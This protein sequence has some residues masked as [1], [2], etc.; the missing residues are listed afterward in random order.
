MISR[1]FFIGTLC[2]GK[3]TFVAAE[4]AAMVGGCKGGD[5]YNGATGECN[6]YGTSCTQETCE[7]D[8]GGVWTADCPPCDPDECDPLA[9]TPD[10]PSCTG[11]PE[12][13]DRFGKKMFRRKMIAREKPQDSEEG[14]FCHATFQLCEGESQLTQGI[15]TGFG[16]YYRIAAVEEMYDYTGTE[17]YSYAGMY[18]PTGARSYS[19]VTPLN[20]NYVQLTVKEVQ[21][22]PVAYDC[23]AGKDCLFGMSELICMAPIGTDF[24]LSRD[25]D[26][27]GYES[28]HQVYVPNFSREPGFGPYTINVIGQGVAITELNL[29]AMS[30]LLQPYNKDG[31]FSNIEVVNY[32]WANSYWSNA[33]WVWNPTEST[34]LSRQFM[35]D[36][37]KY[38]IRFNLMHA[39]SRETR[40]EAEYPRTNTTVIGMA[41]NLTN[42]TDQ[43][44]NTKWFVVGSSGYKKSIYPQ[45]LEWGF[46]LVPCNDAAASKG[47]PYCGPNALY[48]QADYGT[49]PDDRER[50]DLYEYFEGVEAMKD[51]SHDISSH[52]H[53]SHD[54]AESDTGCGM[55]GG[56]KSIKEIACSTSYF[57]VMCESI[58]AVD[59]EDMLSSGTGTYTAFFPTDEAFQKVDSFTSTLSDEQLLN[60]FLFHFLDGGAMMYEDLECKESIGMTNGQDSRTKCVGEDKYQK[61]QG[62][63]ETDTLPMIFSEV[64]NIMAC[65]GVIHG[66]D[67]VMLPDDLP[68]EAMIGK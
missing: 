27:A 20:E 34:D 26:Q 29:L 18:K 58:R 3:A 68:L 46:D 41:F 22:D 61:G 44:P 55:D 64:S 56:L 37:G 31:N 52:D 1:L 19:P 36:L 32:L 28:T 63:H 45:I 67:G 7:G 21:S 2:L 59:E 4:D 40:P 12:A 9:P 25:P 14:V 15:D 17:E 53:S 66:L 51:D 13:I 42:T 10:D 11:P 33:E 65:N 57:S 16:D 54:H 23:T 38:G 62:N 30:E 35:R 48:N 43:D 8:M 5:T 24:L 50:S 39:I 6:C 49:D 47:Y 60:V